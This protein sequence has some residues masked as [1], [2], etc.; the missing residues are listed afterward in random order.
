MIATIFTAIATFVA[1][2]IDHLFILV[3]LFSRGKGKHQIKSVFLGQ[4]LGSAALV[5]FSLLAAFGLSFIPQQWM[6]G[7]LGL[8]PIGL[9]LKVLLKGEEKE[10]EDEVMESAHKF[11]SLVLSLMFLTIACG[12]DNIGIYVPLFSSITSAEIRV[13]IAVYFILV[14]VLCFISYR[15]ARFKHIGETIEKYERIIVPVIF[16]GL[17]IMILVENG[18]FTFLLSLLG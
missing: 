14:A 17:G 9:G 16:I 4:Y 8:I 13:T 1:T 15:I 7:L 11:S 10:G 12:G 6:I 2:H 3:I 5:V 18:T